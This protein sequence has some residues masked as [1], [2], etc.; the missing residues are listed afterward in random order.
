LTRNHTF[1]L[2]RFVKS[3]F[4]S[5]YDDPATEDHPAFDGALLFPAE[6]SGLAEMQ[7]S[8]RSDFEGA[9]WEPYLLFKAWTFEQRGDG[10]ATVFVRFRDNA[11]NISEVSA[12]AV[13]V[14]MTVNPEPPS[15]YLPWI[16]RE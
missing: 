1:D 7:L 3:K 5:L 8:S 13:S 14:D 12:L 16:Q 4:L 9:T 6:K 15:I 10:E 11:G 2:L